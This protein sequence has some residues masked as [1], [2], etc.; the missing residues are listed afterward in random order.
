MCLFLK[1][2]ILPNR[3]L[4]IFNHLLLF[5]CTQN[6]RHNPF[7][8]AHASFPSQELHFTARYSSSENPISEE[9]D[10][11][12]EVL[13]SIRKISRLDKD[14]FS[15]EEREEAEQIFEQRRQEELANQVSR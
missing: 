4:F 10:Y 6:S 15:E 7:S 8:R 9:D 13:I 3:S 1:D 12:L 2:A 11:R 5:F 14:E